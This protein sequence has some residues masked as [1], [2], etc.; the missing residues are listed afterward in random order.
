MRHPI[1]SILTVSL[2]AL[3][4]TTTLAAETYL[5]LYAPA[6]CH[7]VQRA[8]CPRCVADWATPN[9]TC[10]YGGYYVGGGACRDRG[11]CRCPEQG[12]W[13]WDYRGRILPRV[14]ALGWWHPPRL[15][16]GAGSYKT[17]GPHCVEAALHK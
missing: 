1:R 9:D 5:S 13:G 10:D 7:E 17:D 14:V 4:A 11:P 15:Q 6:C 16:G 12:T 8:G 3:L 2:A